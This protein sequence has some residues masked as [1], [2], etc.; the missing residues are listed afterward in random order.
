[1]ELNNNEI[2]ERPASIWIYSLIWAI[3][4]SFSFGFIYACLARID[5][6]VIAKGELQALGAER[7]I[8]APLSG[9]INEIY[10]KEGDLVDKNS[11]LL[12]FDNNVLLARKEG[13]K[14]KLEELESSIK[15]EEAILKELNI[16]ANAGGIQKL[17]Y[18]QQKNKVSELGFAKKQ[19]EAEIKEINFDENKTLLV[20]PVKGK[21]FNLISVSQGFAANQGETL[22]KIVPIG[23]TEAKIF[24]K[25]SDIGFVK[26]NMKANIR[27]DAYPFTQFGSINGIL[28]SIGD[29][30]IRSN[31]QNQNSLFP[32]YVSLEKQYLEKNNQKYFVRSGQSVS[33]NL[34]VR[35]RRIISLLTDAID[36]AIDS[37]RGIK[38]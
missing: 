36:K 5:E 10:I 27:V 24:L 23:D 9:I 38:S 1:M 30:V 18:L 20:S 28:K 26:T 16:L 35:D 3:I 17:Q 25:N 15:A 22:L 31:E 32:A 6:V 2:L 8:R 34:I 14:V 29:E 7:P 37:L 4:G 13:L 21:V 19:I 11:N 33:V 12:R